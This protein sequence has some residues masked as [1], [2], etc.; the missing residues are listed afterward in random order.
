MLTVVVMRGDGAD[1]WRVRTTDVAKGIAQGVAVRIHGLVATSWELNGRAGVSL[2]A[3]R[4]EP[5][6]ATRQAA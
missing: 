1:V 5:A 4:I 6:S 3:E 2:R